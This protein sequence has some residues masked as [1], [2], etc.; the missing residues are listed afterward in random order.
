[1][2]LILV[3]LDFWCQKIQIANPIHASHLD[4]LF[5]SQKEVNIQTAKHILNL[6]LAQ[7]VDLENLPLSLVEELYFL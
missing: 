6:F 2:S 3:R 5:L 4:I 7:N 1:M